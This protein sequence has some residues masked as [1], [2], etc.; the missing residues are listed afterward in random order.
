M[1]DNDTSL[2]IT[3]EVSATP[4]VRA[5]ERPEAIAFNLRNRMFSGIYAFQRFDIKESTGELVVKPDDD[6]GPAYE[7]E[8]VAERT[9]RIDGLSRLSRVKS[10]RRE[11]GIKVEAAP[12]AS[13]IDVK[14]TERDAR[15]KML[16]EQWLKNLP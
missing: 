2:W 9:F 1:L 10:I 6:L 4:I 13:M 11:D 7:L 16:L 15:E 8:T 5:K 14:A 3:H 12:I